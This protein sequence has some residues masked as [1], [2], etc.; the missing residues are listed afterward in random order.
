VS[1]RKL[2][3][4]YNGRVKIGVQSRRIRPKNLKGISQEVEQHWLNLSVNSYQGSAEFLSVR[5]KE[6]MC[7]DLEEAELETRL[8]IGH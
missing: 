2:D 1:C 4:R 7:F 8:N 6:R 5:F 3:T